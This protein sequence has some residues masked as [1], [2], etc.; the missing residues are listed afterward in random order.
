M[1]DERR[2]LSLRR[3]ACLLRHARPDDDWSLMDPPPSEPQLRR[4][5]RR[6]GD[7]PTTQS[8]K[9]IA[10]PIVSP[11]L[12]QRTVLTFLEAI[13]PTYRRLHGT[14]AEERPRGRGAQ[15]NRELRTGRVK[16]GVNKTDIVWMPRLTDRQTD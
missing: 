8:A 14:R 2:Y 10:M 15:W 7:I 3:P 1:I 9:S 13:K 11:P 5:R 4:A 12:E 16:I 6:A